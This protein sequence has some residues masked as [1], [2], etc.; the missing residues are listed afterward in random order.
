MAVN[1]DERRCDRCGACVGVCPADALMLADSLEVVCTLCTNCNR[2][3]GICPFGA[4]SLKIG[5]ELEN[6]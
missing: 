4:L 3:V 2:C 1:V 6:G 5:S